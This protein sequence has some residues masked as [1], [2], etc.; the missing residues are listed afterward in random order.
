LI[1]DLQNTQKLV[2]GVAALVS[3]LSAAPR[4]YLHTTNGVRE[5]VG[6]RGRRYWVVSRALCRFF[7]VPLAAEAAVSNQLDALALQVARL[8][9]FAETGSHFHFTEDFV[10]LWLWDLQAVRNAGEAIG[11]DVARL[12]ILPE[13]ALLPAAE[14]GVRLV[15]TIE[16]VEAQSWRKGS[17]VASRRWPALPARGDDAGAVAARL[18]RPALDAEP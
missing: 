5:P 14:E 18:A 3:R 8:S 6:R 13:T 17:L 15:R 7:K 10:S 2:P 12:W 16:G 9:P 1:L 11:V 4:L